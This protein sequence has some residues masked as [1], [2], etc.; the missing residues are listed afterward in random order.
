MKQGFIRKASMLGLSLLVASSVSAKSLTPKAL[1]ARHKPATERVM[2]LDD[3]LQSNGIQLNAATSR[4]LTPQTKRLLLE[5]ARYAENHAEP[6][7]AAQMEAVKENAVPF[8]ARTLRR[9]SGDAQVLIAGDCHSESDQTE[10]LAR[11]LGVF[12]EMGV[13]AIVVEAIPIPLQGDM[14]AYFKTG[15]MSPELHDHISSMYYYHCPNVHAAHFHL[16]EAA[17][18]Q[19]IRLYAAGASEMVYAKNPA[20]RAAPDR[21]PRY[22]SLSNAVSNAVIECAI[23]C[24]DG[25]PDPGGKVLV[26]FG[27]DHGPG[28]SRLLREKGISSCVIRLAVSGEGAAQ[29]KWARENTTKLRMGL[30]ENPFFYG[31]DRDDVHYQIV[32]RALDGSDG[33][34]LLADLPAYVRSRYDLVLYFPVTP[35]PRAETSLLR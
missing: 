32:S 9:L 27:R 15:M 24:Q 33:P 26:T 35:K 18:A 2:T 5:R 1:F 16:L 7:S 17:R 14:N 28:M 19:G 11:N 12:R 6:V 21:Y 30:V 25:N 29:E 22:I 20:L 31:P 8:D 3:S 34:M 23:P 4:L 13:K 10:Y